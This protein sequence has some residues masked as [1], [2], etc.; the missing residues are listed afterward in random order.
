[1]IELLVVVAI[2]ALLVSILMPSLRNALNL[3]KASGCLSHLSTAGKS[4]AMYQSANE[5]YVFPPSIRNSRIAITSIEVLVWNEYLP[6]T[7]YG[8]CPGAEFELP[9]YSKRELNYRVAEDIR[10]RWD[11]ALPFWEASQKVAFG[12]NQYTH[13]GWKSIMSGS[14]FDPGAY[15]QVENLQR[16]TKEIYMMDAVYHQRYWQP[17]TT[18]WTADELK[19]DPTTSPYSDGPGAEPWSYFESGAGQADS[20]GNR[21]YC[22]ASVRHNYKTNTL[23]VTGSAM[24][25]D[26]NEGNVEWGASGNM[27][28]ME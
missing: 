26:L 11:S 9:V 3:A 6:D 19:E 5:G 25:M 7:S 13:I 28:D 18:A 8:T 4:L 15:L 16:P 20:D 2:I 17:W 12:G 23:L 1:L 10:G 22:F 14:R 27:F 24:P 21:K